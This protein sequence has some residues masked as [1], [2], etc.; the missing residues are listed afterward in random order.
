M[1]GPPRWPSRWASDG[2]SLAVFLQRERQAIRGLTPVAQRILGIGND[3]AGSP[4]R[5][6]EILNMR[7]AEISQKAKRLKCIECTRLPEL[8]GFTSITLFFENEDSLSFCVDED[9]D[10]LLYDS[11]CMS[12]MQSTKGKS[13]IPK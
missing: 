9:T 4:R 6:K 1:I 12:Y 13:L 8:T 2:W 5:S 11:R 7:L 3:Q 10:E